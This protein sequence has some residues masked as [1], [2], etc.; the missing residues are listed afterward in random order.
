M[1]YQWELE[2]RWALSPNAVRHLESWCWRH[3]ATAGGRGWATCSTLPHGQWAVD[4][5]EGSGQWG[6]LCT[7]PHCRVR[8]AVGILLFTA[9]CR[10]QWAVGI[11]QI[12]ATLQGA[13]AM[14]ILLL[15]PHC[16]GQ[17][18]VGFLLYTA[19]LLRQGAVEILQ[20]NA[21]LQGAVGS[22]DPSIQCHT[23]G[24]SGEWGSSISEPH[25]WGRRAVG[26]LLCACSYGKVS[27]GMNAFCLMAI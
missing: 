7:L 23:S 26:I 11:P 27:S 13:V 14:W 16:R 4:T 2:N 12:A 3:T 5:A 22:G 1:S 9:T 18:A 19:T 21:V 8:W 20:C 24:G 15:L 6:S 17:W 25:G 10:G